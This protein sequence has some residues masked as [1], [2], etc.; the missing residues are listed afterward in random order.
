MSGHNNEGS[1][2]SYTGRVSNE[3]KYE[4]SHTLAQTIGFRNQSV[5]EQNHAALDEPLPAT[6]TVTQP[7]NLTAA[8]PST[9]TRPPPENGHDGMRTVTTPQAPQH[10]ATAA[11]AQEEDDFRINFDLELPSS[12]LSQIEYAFEETDVVQEEIAPVQPPVSGN[13]VLQPIENNQHVTTARTSRITSSS[14]SRRMQVQQSPFVFNNC[15]VTI[16]Y[17]KD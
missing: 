15:S 10:T 5:L 3:R 8:P 13:G 7:A 2:A 11:A 14:T 6:V 4:M 9:V 17:F 1:L 12:Q 16:N